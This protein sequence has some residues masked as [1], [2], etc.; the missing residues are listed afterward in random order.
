[1]TYVRTEEI[2]H[3]QSI[4][5]RQKHA[6]GSYDWHEIESKRKQTYEQKGTKPGRKPGSGPAKRGEYK[7]CPVCEAPVYYKP[8]QIKEGRRKCCSRECLRADPVYRQKLSNVDKSYLQTE[9]YR[10]SLRKTSTKEYRRYRNNVARLT[11]WTYVEYMEVIN[12]DKHPRT[13]AGVEGGWQ[14]D[15]IKPVRECFDEGVPPEEAAHVS[16]LR[17]LPWRENLARNKRVNTV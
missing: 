2:K 15:H 3:K 12:P 7:P 1:M 5:M 4:S 16:N 14:L 11:E 8:K 13:I 6:C 17:M 9:E 10:A